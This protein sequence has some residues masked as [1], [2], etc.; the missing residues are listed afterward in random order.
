MTDMVNDLTSVGFT[1]PIAP[2][3][4]SEDGLLHESFLSLIRLTTRHYLVYSFSL[5]QLTL[6]K[7]ALADIDRL[8]HKTTVVLMIQD[9]FRTCNIPELLQILSHSQRPFSDLPHI[10]RL[11]PDKSLLYKVLP[12]LLAEP[13]LLIG[14]VAR[15]PHLLPFQI[16]QL[17]ALFDYEDLFDTLLDFKDICDKKGS[18]S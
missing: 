8:Y 10:L 15:L 7:K 4:V 16:E 18:I 1:H 6:L 9:L 13:P 11:P 12:P 3:A 17:G 14:I 5:E 2:H